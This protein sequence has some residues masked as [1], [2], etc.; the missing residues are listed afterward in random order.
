LRI[1]EEYAS[2]R[3]R[4]TKPVSSEEMLTAPIPAVYNKTA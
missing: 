2:D 3:N 1:T 4:I